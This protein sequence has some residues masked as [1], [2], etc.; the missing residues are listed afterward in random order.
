M[1]NCTTKNPADVRCTPLAKIGAS[2]HG[3]RHHILRYVAGIA[4]LAVAACQSGPDSDNTAPKATK[5]PLSVS[6]AHSPAL[7]SL[8]HS[9]ASQFLAQK[10]ITSAGY[11]IE[12]E[13]LAEDPLVAGNQIANGRMKVDSWLAPMSSLVNL[14]NSSIRNL[15]AKQIN[16]IDVF[17]SPLVAA[18]TKEDAIRLGV[19]LASPT[20]PFRSFLE[21]SKKHPLKIAHGI[22]ENSAVGLGAL[23]QM[24]VVHT[25]A[26]TLTSADVS[27]GA[28]RE[29]IGSYQALLAEYHDD[30]S[31]LLQHAAT[32]I[33]A[34]IEIALTSEQA[35]A[36]Y[37]LEQAHSD[38]LL[39]LYPQEPNIWFDHILCHSE[40]EWVTPNHKEALSLFAEFLTSNTFAPEI[41]MNGFRPI[42]SG[43]LSTPLTG[44]FG[45]AANHTFEKATAFE[46]EVVKGLLKEWPALKPP[47]HLVMIIDT[48]GSMEGPSLGT[49]IAQAKKFVEALDDDDQVAVLGVS[50]SA[51]ITNLTSDKKKIAAAITQLRAAGGFAL[52][53]AYK[54]ALSMLIH[55]SN[56]A[57]RK[58]ILII[59][60]GHDTSSVSSRDLAVQIAQNISPKQHISF[61]AIGLETEGETHEDLRLL[62]KPFEGTVVTGKPEALFA[63]LRDYIESL[64]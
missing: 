5:K 29:T 18:I 35:L 24:A 51:T 7:S 21:P 15:G 31:T 25:N 38:P 59:A 58:G 53:D 23:L 48:S 46:G 33:P 26:A 28:L 34:R 54:E 30:E 64:S 17:G 45:V 3:C 14:G 47:R 55:E 41:I 39:A 36:M 13:L 9:A 57:T 60:D 50:N 11:P 56:D 43:T 40:R 8:L 6:I 32:H 1:K 42:S 61:T 37:N 16:C 4:L 2:L 62:A 52:Y 19:D 27:S 10:P 20:V 44:E 49:I 22:P 63:M 12:L